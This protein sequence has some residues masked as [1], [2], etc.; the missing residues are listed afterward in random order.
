[1]KK[2]VVTLLRYRRIGNDRDWPRETPQSRVPI[3]S[4]RDAAL[5]LFRDFSS[6]YQP[7]DVPLGDLQEVTL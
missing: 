4:K 5:T 2:S 1:M 3:I 7:G 6:P